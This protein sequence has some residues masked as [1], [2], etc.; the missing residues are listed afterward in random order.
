MLL[1]TLFIWAITGC[2]NNA[3]SAELTA[4]R[5][6][7]A[8]LETDS[9]PPTSSMVADLLTP[10]VTIEW[11][12]AEPDPFMRFVAK[13]RN[14]NPFPL[15][16]VSTSWE[17]YDA[18]GAYVAAHTR[19]LPVLD[20]NSEFI[21]VGGAGSFHLSG[22]PTRVEIYIEEAGAAEPDA[23]SKNFMVK[24]IT[25]E[26]NLI[27][28]LEMN[29]LIESPGINITGSQIAATWVVYGKN[30][31]ILTADYG[32]GGFPSFPDTLKPSSLLRVEGYI[33]DAALFADEID[34][35]ELRVYEDL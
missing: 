13:I 24:E 31:E 22:H 32:F 9:L 4:L 1:F 21:Y 7:V 30:N 18:D 34:H 10:T 19:E 17:A 20:A 29:A 5:E 15:S 3:D 25:S 2:G 6:Q 26:I 12:Y 27:G 28:A 33:R 23:V 8:A 11:F 16:G 35:I 14:P